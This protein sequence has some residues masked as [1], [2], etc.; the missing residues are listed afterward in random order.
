MP[1]MAWPIEEPTATP[2]ERPISYCL[3][4]RDKECDKGGGGW[5]PRTRAENLGPPFHALIESQGENKRRRTGSVSLAD[6]R[7]S[8]GHLAEQAGALRHLLRRSLVRLRSGHGGGRALLLGSSRRRRR[9]GGSP[10]DGG[11]AGGS[12]ARH[13]GGC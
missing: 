2:L 5:V 8:A 11:A 6:L 4:M 9:S 3:L 7:S 10:G 1:P 12:I 13:S